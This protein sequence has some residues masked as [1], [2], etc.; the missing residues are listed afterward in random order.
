MYAHSVLSRLRFQT[1]KVIRNPMYSIEINVTVPIGCDLR[2][3][4]QLF[5]QNKQLDVYVCKY[6]ATS[7]LW[8]FKVKPR[9]LFVGDG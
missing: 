7:S 2:E 5:F 9:A 1:Q 4:F 6:K 8:N 3:K